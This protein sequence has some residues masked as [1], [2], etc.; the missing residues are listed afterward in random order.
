M[1]TLTETVELLIKYSRYDEAVDLIAVAL[2]IGFKCEFL[3]NDFHFANDKNK[4]DIYKITIKRGDRKYSFKF[5]QSI[6]KSGFYFQM[7]RNRV[8]IDRK[9]T[10]ESKQYLSANKL[11]LNAFDFS[12]KI[13]SIHYPTAPTL[14]EVLTCLQKYEVGTFEDFCGDFGYDNDSRSAFKI[15][16][17]VVKEY[18]AMQRLFTNEELEVLRLIK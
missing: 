1:E 13:D 17:A 7:G 2:N 11:K 5:G 9:Y 15:H 16:K 3:K 6:N 12:T 10:N 14:Y 8:E 4:R 18:E